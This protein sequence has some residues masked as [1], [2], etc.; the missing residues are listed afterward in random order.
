MT[1][2]LRKR[3]TDF[4]Q[5]ELTR[6]TL[7][8]AEYLVNHPSILITADQAYSMAQAAFNAGKT[9]QERNENGK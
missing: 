3:L 9:Y 7:A 2:P 4:N 5:I 6:H 1:S 8:L